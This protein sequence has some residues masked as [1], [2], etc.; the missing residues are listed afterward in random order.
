MLETYIR[1]AKVLRVIDGDT[2]KLTIDLG[3][4]IYHTRSVRLANI[5]APE[6]N[7]DAG[8]AAKDWLVEQL[9]IGSDVIVKTVKTTDK[10]GRYIAI[11][12]VGGGLMTINDRLVNAGHAVAHIY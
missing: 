7:T 5:N 2:L 3:L 6:M 10:Y 1:N 12:Y 8:K 9:P 4:D 11:L